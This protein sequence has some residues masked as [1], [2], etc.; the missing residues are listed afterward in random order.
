MTFRVERARRGLLTMGMAL[1][2]AAVA[3]LAPHP[4]AAR[5][6]YAAI[7]VDAE[8]GAILHQRYANSTRHPASLTKMMT[9]YLTF[10]ALEQGRLSLDQ[11]LKVSRR[12]SRM[13][14][15]KLFL[16]AGRT[17]KV[18]DAILGLVTKS[19]NDAAVV[20]AEALGGSESK[21]ARLMT[22][23]ARALGMSKTTFRNASGL[24]HPAQVTTAKDMA[25]LGIAL[26]RDHPDY[27]DFFRTRSFKFA[28][29]SHRNHNHL[30]GRYAG[31]DGI[32]TGYIRASGFNLVASVKRGNKRLVGVVMGGL[33]MMT[34]NWAFM[35]SFI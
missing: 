17:V 16:R 5:N 13:P 10:D 6:K 35:A 25:T 27:Y 24:H 28:G 18:R 1:L 14:R 30:L 7:I 15:T 3:A 32:K 33:Q 31:T 23:K 29:R 19:A 9:L 21:F 20:L 4:A 2:I 22:A 11:R 26:M 12:A 34:L 8:S